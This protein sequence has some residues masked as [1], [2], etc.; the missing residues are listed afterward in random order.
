MITVLLIPSIGA[1]VSIGMIKTA[2]AD[3]LACEKHDVV[4]IGAEGAGRLIFLQ[5]DAPLVGKDLKGILFFQIQC[6]ADLN[7]QHKAPQLIDLSGDSGGFH[8]IFLLNIK[9][10]V[11]SVLFDL[12]FIINRRKLDVNTQ[13]W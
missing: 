8:H 10:R 6:T 7:G 9:I 2:F 13:K 5:N 12:A 11:C 1:R 4:R 3:A